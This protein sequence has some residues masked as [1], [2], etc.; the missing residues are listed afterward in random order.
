MSCVFLNSGVQRAHNFA[1]PAT[2][3][4]KSVDLEITT[5]YTSF[6]HM[7]AAF[8]PHLQ[9]LQSAQT[10]SSIVYVTSGLALVPIPRVL[11]YCSTKSALHHFILPLREE[12]REPYEHLKIIELLPPAVQTEL[13]NEKHQPDLKPGVGAQTGI[14]LADFLREAWEKLETGEEEIMVGDMT[15][16]MAGDW[17]QQ[18]QAEFKQRFKFISE[19]NKRNMKEGY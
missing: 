7:T 1:K 3:D 8:L 19:A 15:K 5:N 16:N 4:L 9:K 2:I 10:P 12:L 18:R 17:E 6:I 14:T 13:H 11:V